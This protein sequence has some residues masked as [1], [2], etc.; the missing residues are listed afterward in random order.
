[1]AAYHGNA[2]IVETLLNNNADVFIRDSFGKRASHRAKDPKI[3]KMLQV[4]EASTNTGTMT[5]IASEKNLKLNLNL[6]KSDVP[7]IA[8]Q[9]SLKT[10]V[11]SSVSEL[12]EK[13]KPDATPQ[14][15]RVTSPRS[16][17]NRSPVNQTFCYKFLIM[18]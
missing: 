2:E 18:L 13:K 7:S 11:S 9:S 16:P 1:M 4:V 12:P 10:A 6:T 17:L 8:Q 14:T 3:V 15:K 5:T